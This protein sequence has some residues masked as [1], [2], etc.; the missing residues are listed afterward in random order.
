MSTP[1][2]HEALNQLFLEARTHNG[3][4]DKPVSEELLHEL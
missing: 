1:L 4:L 2:N 3:W